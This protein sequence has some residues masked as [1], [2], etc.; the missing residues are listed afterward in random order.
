MS[1][2]VGINFGQLGEVR[3]Q[4]DA[5]ITEFA[6]AGA[7]AEALEA[8]IATPYGRSELRDKAG[9]FE[10]RWSNKRSSLQEELTGVRD[11]VEGVLEGFQEMDDEMAM[12]FEN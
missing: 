4:L 10:S 12:M 8:A 1:H 11:H 9:D 7:L 6:N 2:D 5:I 3:E